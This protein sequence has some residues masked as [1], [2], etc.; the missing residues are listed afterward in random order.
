M[1]DP[2][3]QILTLA[4]LSSCVLPSLVLAD[5]CEHEK[6]LSFTVD[7]SGIQSLD[8]DV[9]AGYLRVRGD[10]NAR[11]VQVDARACA[12]SARRLEGLDLVFEQDNGKLRIESREAS[13]TGFS[14]SGS[15]YARINIDLVVPAA[16]Q[17]SIDD[18]S[19][20]ITVANVNEGLQIK[21]DSGSI[22]LE[23]IGGDVRIEDGSGN[24]EVLAVTGNVD[25]DD[26]SGNIRISDV[27]GSVRVRDNSGSIRI[28]QVSG[29]VDIPDDGSGS[30]TISNVGGSVRI[31]NDGSG[32]IDVFDVEGD[33]TARNTGSGGVDYSR[34][35]GKVDVRE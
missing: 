6:D 8:I 19:G 28:D 24:I 26:D 20:E 10:E 31:D 2:F 18:D 34:I 17:V 13:F 22:A 21:D 25:I 12:D 16:T 32:N 1:T 5:D 29:D 14:L 3:R 33:F 9:G 11:Q 7:A 15:R 30:I 35:G 23:N 27:R 4:L